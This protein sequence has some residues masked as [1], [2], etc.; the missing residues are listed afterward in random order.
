MTSSYIPKNDRNM[1]LQR[2]ITI[3]HQWQFAQKMYCFQKGG[4][5]TS[6]RWVACLT[7]HIWEISCT[8][9]EHCNHS[10][11]NDAKIRKSLYMG[12]Y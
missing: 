9:W 8:L 3:T 2:R 12:E 5:E 10:I 11:H 4:H 6:K 7:E 1:E